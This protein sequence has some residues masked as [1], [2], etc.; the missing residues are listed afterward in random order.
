M[1]TT[2]AE[3]PVDSGS[4]EAALESSFGYS[5]PEPKQPKAPEPQPEPQEAQES[6][7]DQAEDTSSDEL[8]ADDLPEVEAK[9]PQSADDEFLEI[10]HD[11][12]QR[13][14]TREEAI[15]YSQQ[16]YDYT[17]KAQ[18]V[19]QQRQE[20]TQRMAQLQEMQQLQTALAPEIAQVEALK[21]QLKPF[22]NVDWVRLAQENPLD[23]A[24]YHAQF[25]TLRDTLQVAEQ[26]VNGKVGQLREQQKQLQ[27]KNVADQHKLL[28]E[29]NPQWRDPEKFK[30]MA[31]DVTEYLR[32]KGLPQERIDSLSDA[33]SLEIA[34]DAAQYQKLLRQ[35]A[36][37]VKQIRTAPP[38]VKPG[39]V[40]QQTDG[41]ADFT[42]FQ[43]DFR[44][45]GKKGN[46]RGQENLLLQRL[47]RAFKI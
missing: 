9:S 34:A 20:L 19:A 29:R 12:T 24:K 37:R 8:T 21:T 15:R 23:Y 6:P 28:L 31:R 46:S 22:Q 30:G 36:E 7:A 44:T 41:K 14:L 1:E 39:V 32:Q 42:K 16:G 13:K 4:L 3:T 5:Q 40:S 27:A 33:I 17:Q 38:V 35:K 43:K 18:A 2:K 11:G 45:A 47:N 25:Q 10:V 26:Q